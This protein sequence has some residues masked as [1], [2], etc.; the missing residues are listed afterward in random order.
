[1]ISVLEGPDFGRARLL[2]KSL[3]KDW[4]DVKVVRARKKDFSELDAALFNE[5]NIIVKRAE[6][7]GERYAE[8][9]PSWRYKSL[10]FVTDTALKKGVFSRKSK[11]LGKSYKMALGKV[12]KE[13]IQVLADQLAIPPEMKMALKTRCFSVSEALNAAECYALTGEIPSLRSPPLILFLS[14]MCFPLFDLPL[15]VLAR[16]L[17]SLASAVGSDTKGWVLLKKI[18]KASPGAVGV[19]FNIFQKLRDDKNLRP[20]LLKIGLLLSEKAE[21]VGSLKIPTSYFLLMT[22]DFDKPQLRPEGER[23]G[24]RFSFRDHAGTK[25]AIGWRGGGRGQRRPIR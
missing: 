25:S 22:K 9:I 5:D 19:I 1:M 3:T 6:R 14:E 8:Y 20:F 7:L 15:P 11:R 12:A 17:S 18:Q 23:K 21:E 16:H 2:I 13:K 10:I 24:G 4:P